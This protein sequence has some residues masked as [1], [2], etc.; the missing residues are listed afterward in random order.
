MDVFGPVFSASHNVFYRITSNCLQVDIMFASSYQY[1]TVS[2]NILNQIVRF[3]IILCLS[4]NFVYDQFRHCFPFQ[5]GYPTIYDN[6]AR[7]FCTGVEPGG[8]GALSPQD[9]M[10][11]MVSY[12]PIPI[13]SPLSP[14]YNHSAATECPSAKFTERARSCAVSVYCA[15]GHRKY[16][17]EFTLD[18]PIALQ[19]S[20]HCS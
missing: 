4:T 6:S 10:C 5:F 2:H 1:C 9:G 11:S 17:K 19:P 8:L 3:I 12:H 20:C 13:Q 18:S 15:R 7:T 14:T 16:V